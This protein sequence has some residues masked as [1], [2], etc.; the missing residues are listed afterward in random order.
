M[1]YSKASSRMFVISKALFIKDEKMLLKLVSH[2]LASDV[3]Y[4]S[5]IFCPSKPKD[6]V[7]F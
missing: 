2:V 1:V 4:G 3:V 5:P 6:I 7:L